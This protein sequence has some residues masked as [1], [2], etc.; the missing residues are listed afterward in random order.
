M[1]KFLVLYNSQMSAAE[2][3]ANATPEEAKAGMDAWMAWAGEAGDAV[4]DLGMP[5]GS[6]KHLE[7]G[8]TTDG[9]NPASGYSILEA[10]SLETASGLVENHPH[11]GVPGN[12]IDVMEFL[13]MPGMGTEPDA[14]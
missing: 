7:G 14:S 2:V 6:S 5:L 1:A 12:T 4:L 13:P 11:L 9:S 8:S 3:M 10:G